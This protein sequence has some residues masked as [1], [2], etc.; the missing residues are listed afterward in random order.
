MRHLALLGGPIVTPRSGNQ[1]DK[2]RKLGTSRLN[3]LGLAMGKYHINSNGVDLLT[4]GILVNCGYNRIMSDNL[5]T[6]NNDSIAAYRRILDLW[7]NPTAHTFGPQVN[8]ILLKSFKLFPT[9]DSIRMDDMV[10]FYDRFQELSTSHLLALMPFDA[11]TLKHGFEG[12]CLPHLGPTNN[13]IPNP[14]TP[15][16]ALP[17]TEPPPPPSIDDTFPPGSLFNVYS[18]ASSPCSV[19]MDLRTKQEHDSALTKLPQW[20]SISDSVT[21][22]VCTPCICGINGDLVS[23]ICIL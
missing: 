5:V 9:L 19:T 21:H 13:T 22:V 4:S 23:N 17:P 8:Q 14:T 3:I 16:A 10:D 1:E 15:S 18:C 11:I 7:H 2:V 6:C 12:L 20:P